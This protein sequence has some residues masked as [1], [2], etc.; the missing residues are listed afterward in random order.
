MI[1]VS[2]QLT[3]INAE[4]LSDSLP[5]SLNFNVNLALPSGNPYM[6]DNRFVIPFT[7]TVTTLPPLV[8]ITLKGRAIVFS[9][10]TGEM[11]RI[12]SDVRKKK[13]P[14][15]ILQAVFINMIAESILISRSLGTP[16]PLPGIP[17]ITQPPKHE[18]KPGPGT[19]I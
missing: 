6:Q 13:I 1:N 7:F 9:D 5:P 3:S 16:P 15:P 2:V 11:K 12:E 18:K 4:R 14:A 17:G 10:D 19:F 8:N